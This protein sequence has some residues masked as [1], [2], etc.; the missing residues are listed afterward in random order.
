[1]D[2]SAPMEPWLVTRDELPDPS[3][4]EIS[5]SVNGEERQRSNT[6]NFVFT[7]QRLV[8]FLSELMTL[9]PGDVI[10]PI[11]ILGELA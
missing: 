8:E 7:V 11:W 6:A 1:M 10:L 4:L 9:E 3:G 2:G 5:L